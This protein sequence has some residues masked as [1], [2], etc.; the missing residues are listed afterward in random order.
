[1]ACQRW[2]QRVQCWTLRD[3]N[4]DGTHQLD[5]VAGGDYAGTELVI[6]GELALFEFLLKMDI[7]HAAGEELFER[8]QGQIMRGHQA[9]GPVVQQ[10][11]QDSLRA[12]AAIA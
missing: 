2:L 8:G 10:H 4:P 5:A 11:T 12:D 3:V 6:E 7:A 1:M 9:D